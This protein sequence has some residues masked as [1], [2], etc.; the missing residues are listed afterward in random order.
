MEYIVKRLGE[1]VYFNN[2]KETLTSKQ[3]KGIIIITKHE[4]FHGEGSFY[5]LLINMS[6]VNQELKSTDRLL[7]EHSDNLPKKEGNE[8]YSRYLYICIHKTS[9]IIITVHFQ[10]SVDDLKFISIFKYK[11]SASFILYRSELFARGTLLY[12]PRL[13]RSILLQPHGYSTVTIVDV[14]WYYS[15]EM[16]I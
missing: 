16:K 3:N 7:N 9:L 13:T 11:C 1:G 6:N 15:R 5:T 4:H 2:N 14:P 12:R 8:K 10:R